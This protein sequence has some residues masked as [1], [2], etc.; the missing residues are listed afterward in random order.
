MISRVDDYAILFSSSPPSSSPVVSVRKELRWDFRE[1][2]SSALETTLLVLGE[3]PADVE[4][5]VVVVSD[6]EDS[7]TRLDALVVVGEGFVLPQS[8]GEDSIFLD[9][10]VD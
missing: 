7:V 9:L 2:H 10:R 1:G 8:F 3:D 6:A 4:L 5:G